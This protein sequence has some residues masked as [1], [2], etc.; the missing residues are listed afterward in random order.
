MTL[1]RK[2]WVSVLA[3][4]IGLMGNVFGQQ[5]PGFGNFDIA[6]LYY[7]PGYAG[8]GDGLRA[9]ALNRGQWNGIDGAPNS[10]LFGVESPIGKGIGMGL[11]FSNDQVGYIRDNAFSINGSYRIYINS[12]SYIQGGLRIGASFIKTGN[13]DAFQWDE[14]DPVK[15]N[16]TATVPR[17][18]F[19]GFYHNTDFYVGIAAPDIMSFDVDN[20]FVNDQTNESSLRNNYFLIAGSEFDITEYTTF[21]PALIVRYYSTRPITFTFNAGFQLNQTITVGATYT[22]EDVYGVFGMVSLTP[23]LRA[24]Y[25][26]EFSPVAY[27]TSELGTGEFVISY[28]FQ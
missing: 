17:I 5:M 26:H 28:G 20:A 14:G 22:Y 4:A 18:G 15:E 21:K 11:T 27:T 8:S 3:L 24:G 7:N 25:R 2:Q 6:H 10:T 9:F 16:I 23:K 19:G 13:I 12:S 1:N